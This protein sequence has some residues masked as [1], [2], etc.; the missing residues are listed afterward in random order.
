MIKNILLT[1]A[2]L[3]VGVATAMAHSNNEIVIDDDI[4]LYHLQDSIYVHV[5]WHYLDNFGRFPSNGLLVIENGKALMV[6][7]PMDND[8]TA[9]LTN[10]LMDELSVEVTTIIAG[11]FHNDCLG[12]LEYLQRKGAGS[13]ANALTISKCKELGLPVPATSFSD[14]LTFNFN[15]K[16][17]VC[18]Y[19]GA[20]H[21]VDNITVWIPENKIL[22][23]GCLIK[24]LDSPNLG[25]LV[26]AVVDEWATT[27]EKL[28]IEYADV[29]TVIP[30]HGAFGGSALLS[31]TVALVQQEQ[32]K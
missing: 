4:Q 7:T 5:T 29:E 26:D 18:R 6:D 23:G 14:S 21:T 28:M 22:F 16:Q 2:F 30:G 9:R 27:V 3:L 31:H 32:N 24:S 11:H 20:G 17:I 25:N 10:Y 13:I 12:G 15:G 1:A 19:F 8:K